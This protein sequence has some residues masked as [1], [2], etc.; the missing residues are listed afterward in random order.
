MPAGIT[1]ESRLLG[2]DAVV[3][4]QWHHDVRS[5]QL[6]QSIQ[7]KGFPQQLEKDWVATDCLPQSSRCFTAFRIQRRRRSGIIQLGFV[8]DIALMSSEVPLSN[9]LHCFDI[10]G[11][12]HSPRDKKTVTLKGTNFL[13]KKAVYCG[14]I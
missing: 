7:H 14:V 12:H 10:G 6:L 13:V 4:S 11:G 3:M 1:A 8:L 2:H 5:Q 9:L